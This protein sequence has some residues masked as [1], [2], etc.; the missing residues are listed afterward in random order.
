MLEGG[1]AE[2]GDKVEE[3]EKGGDEGDEK[4]VEEE[5]EE[6]ANNEDGG[7]EGSEKTEGKTAEEKDVKKVSGHRKGG[8][9][10]GGEHGDDNADDESEDEKVEDDF[11]AE[12][13]K[14]GKGINDFLL[15]MKREVD[16]D[17]NHTPGKSRGG[18]RVTIMGNMYK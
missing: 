16:Q 1:K 10:D 15:N 17:P 14:K 2:G 6:E 4:K 3:E 18:N 7:V 8:G 11:D 12:E 9:E 5:D 13:S